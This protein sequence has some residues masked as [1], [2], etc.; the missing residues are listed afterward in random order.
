MD[1]CEAKEMY[2]ASLRHPDL[3]TQVVPSPLTFEFD[4]TI[5]DIVKKG[6]LGDL[7]YIEASLALPEHYEQR[8]NRSIWAVGLLYNCAFR[9]FQGKTGRPCCQGYHALISGSVRY[10]SGVRMLPV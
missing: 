3:V 5:Q 4:A 10:H 1:A 7:I 2:Q 6:S 9:I 8:R